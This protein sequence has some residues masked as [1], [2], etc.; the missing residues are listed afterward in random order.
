MNW[1]ALIYLSRRPRRVSV[2]DRPDD[3]EL[4]G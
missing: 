3:F 1:L 2:A 4:I